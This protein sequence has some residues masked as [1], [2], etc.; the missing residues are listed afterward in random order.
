M[1]AAVFEQPVTVLFCGDGVW[2]LLS[3]QNGEGLQVKTLA[4]IFPAFDLYDIREIQVAQSSMTER[5]L[6]PGDL[7][8]D[9]ELVADEQVRELIASSKTV[10]V[11]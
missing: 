9:V 7:M 11:F 2:Q 1:T 8:V 5:G 4:R 6:H 3:G 10:F